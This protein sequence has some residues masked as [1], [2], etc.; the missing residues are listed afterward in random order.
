MTP[1]GV[2]RNLEAIEEECFVGEEVVIGKVVAHSCLA[3]NIEKLKLV[4]NMIGW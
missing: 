4:L 1:H 3:I 2:G